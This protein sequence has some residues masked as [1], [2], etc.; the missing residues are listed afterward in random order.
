MFDIVAGYLGPGHEMAEDDP[1]GT[2]SSCKRKELAQASNAGIVQLIA[3]DKSSSDTFVLPPFVTELLRLID[4][5]HILIRF[6]L[7]TL[8]AY[9]PKVFK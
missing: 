8:I 7:K 6:K 4:I 3:E 1:L 9:C 5:R 2:Y